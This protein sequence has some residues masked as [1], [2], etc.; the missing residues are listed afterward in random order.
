M[1]KSM[2]ALIETLFLI[3]K[4]NVSSKINEIFIDS[5]CLV[6]TTPDDEKKFEQYKFSVTIRTGVK[7]EYKKIGNLYQNPELL[8]ESRCSQD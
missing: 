8:K 1:N 6:I 5:P 2:N 3:M 4:E 7:V